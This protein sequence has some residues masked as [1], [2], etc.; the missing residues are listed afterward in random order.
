[1]RHGETIANQNGL[2]QGQ[3]DYPLTE[4]GK[5]VILRLAQKIRHVSFESIFS[6]DLGRAKESS[7]LV[8]NELDYQKPVIYTKALREIDFGDYSRL[9]KKEVMEKIRLHKMNE[10]IP[11]PNGESG[12]DLK[13]RVTDFV[14][15]ILNS[16]QSGNVLV[17]THYGVIETIL[18]NFTDMGNDQIIRFKPSAIALLRFNGTM[19]GWERLEY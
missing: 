1:M 2:I 10:E 15:R 5:Q 18:K 6:S 8:T 7:D 17:V 11:Y 12:L 19:A 13:K 14:H 9:P 3:T 16:V 4:E